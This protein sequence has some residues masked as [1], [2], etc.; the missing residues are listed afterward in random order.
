MQNKIEVRDPE[1]EGA[2]IRRAQEGDDT[3]KA[4]LFEAYR[5]AIEAAAARFASATFDYED[6]YQEACVAFLS[7]V[8]GHDVERSP[9]LAGHVRRYLDFHLKHAATGTTNPF[10]VPGRTFRRYLKVMQEADGDLIA[11]ASLVEKHEMTLST[12]LDIYRIVGAVSLN[13]E[14]F[15]GEGEEQSTLAHAR[16][17]VL[18]GPE[19]PED[20]YDS[21]LTVWE[22]RALM[23]SLDGESHEI[24]RLAYGFDPAVID[25]VEADELPS[26]RSVAAHDDATV[27]EAMTWRHREDGAGY[28]RQKVQRK[29]TA[30]LKTMREKYETEQEEN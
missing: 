19:E 14:A 17:T 26:S 16:V 6:A 5:P 7:L 24:V 10:G 13:R 27:A 28:S 9:V 29:R 22:V 11:A 21:M 30:A 15:D 12:F 2:L 23:D 18:G 20:A 25:G 1:T 4:E 8:E 3:A